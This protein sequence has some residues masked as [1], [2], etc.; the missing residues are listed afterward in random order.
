MPRIGRK[1]G[2]P[3]KATDAKVKGGGRKA[4]TGRK[5]TMARNKRGAVDPDDMPLSPDSLYEEEE[6]AKDPGAG[7]LMPV[8]PFMDGIVSQ[9][10]RGITV[11]P[12]AGGEDAAILHDFL[13]L[14][15][16]TETFIGAIST[17]TS[18]MKKAGGRLL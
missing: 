16:K 5:G 13:G 6:Q 15:A 17:K 12:R 9:A 11:I 14:F 8:E 2:D 4:G 1:G 7:V 18:F 3:S 10:L